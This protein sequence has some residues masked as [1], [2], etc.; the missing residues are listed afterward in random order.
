MK[1]IFTMDLKGKLLIAVVFMVLGFMLSVQIKDKNIK[2][3]YI[4]LTFGKP[5]IKLLPK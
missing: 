4:D 2:A 1:E 5:Y 3:E